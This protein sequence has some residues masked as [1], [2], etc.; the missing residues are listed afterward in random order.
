P[1]HR[2]PPRGPRRRRAAG[3]SRGG[4]SGGGGAR[5]DATAEPRAPRGGRG[6]GGLRRPRAPPGRR[7]RHG[8]GRPRPRVVRL[9][10]LRGAA[11]GRRAGR[12]AHDARRQLAD[13]LRRRPPRRARWAVGRAAR[14]APRHGGQQPRGLARGRHRR[15]GGGSRVA[16]A[17]AP[18]RHPHPAA[19][20]GRHGVRAS[21]G[22]GLGLRAEVA[23]VLPGGRRRRREPRQGRHRGAAVLPGQRRGARPRPHGGG[24]ALGRAPRPRH[25][26]LPSRRAHG[27]GARGPRRP[28][29][30][31]ALAAA[32][33]RGR[34]RGAPRPARRLCRAGVV[35]LRQHRVPRQRPRR[36]AAVWIG[37][38]RAALLAQRRRG[39]L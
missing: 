6:G 7:R 20:R 32:P 19:A 33:P 2:G 4:R 1:R 17:D 13:H 12:G 36:G 5:A 30:L 37:V 3:P 34:L 35:G 10:W 21:L 8:P 11:H 24:A 38:L 27:A 28:G 23:Q 29:C 15:Q 16:A 9:G 18:P 22:R 14:A 31:P 26:P 39:L 25:A